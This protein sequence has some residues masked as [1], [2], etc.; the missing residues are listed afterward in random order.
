M[1]RKEERGMGFDAASRTWLGMA[2]SFLFN[3]QP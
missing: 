1:D 2:E 3:P